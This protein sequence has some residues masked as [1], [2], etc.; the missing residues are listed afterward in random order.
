M[1]L[2]LQAGRHKVPIALATPTTL[3]IARALHYILKLPRRLIHQKRPLGHT[4]DRPSSRQHLSEAYDDLSEFLSLSE[5]KYLIITL[6][7]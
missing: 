6:H 5:I 4:A 1:F 2:E 3:Q 7:L